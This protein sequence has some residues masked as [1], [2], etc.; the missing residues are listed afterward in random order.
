MGVTVGMAERL[1]KLFVELYKEAGA[2][3]VIKELPTARIMNA[4]DT[5]TI[6]A[7]LFASEYVVK[8]RER[9]ILIGLDDHEPLFTF[10]LYGY[11][12]ATRVVEFNNAVTYKNYIIAHIQGN[13]AHEN[14]IAEL[15]A[16]PVPVPDLSNALNMLATGRIDMIMAVPGALTDYFALT[17]IDSTL[18]TMIQKP[19]VSFNYYHVLNNRYVALAESL[20]KVFKKNREALKKMFSGS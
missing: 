2:N 12:L 7:V 17:G 16:R 10:K 13:Q 11:V 5:G 3:V 14:A 18:V 1:R 15:G 6:D 4:F 19:L 9:C 8:N 20:R